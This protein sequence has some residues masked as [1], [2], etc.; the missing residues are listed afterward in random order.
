MVKALAEVDELR[1]ARVLD[2]LQGLT[3]QE[4]EHVLHRAL[5][6]IKRSVITEAGITLVSQPNKS[7]FASGETS[8]ACRREILAQLGNRKELVKELEKFLTERGS[9]SATRKS[10]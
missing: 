6:S 8:D 4:A 5:R 2:D 7:E 1:V 3:I 9:R 10:D